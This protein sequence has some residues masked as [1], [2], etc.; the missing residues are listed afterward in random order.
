MIVPF[1]PPTIADVARRA[2]VSAA[3]V[4]YVLSGRQDQR[5]SAETRERIAQAVTEL[6]Y[7]QNQIA[8]QLR[9]R[10]TK[11]I[12]VLLPQIGIPFADNIAQDVEAAVRQRGYTSVVVVGRSYDMCRQLVLDV[13]AGLADGIVAEVEQFSAHQIS[14]LFEPVARAQ[15]AAL[16]LHPTMEP[17]T[18]STVRQARLPAFKAMLERLHESGRRSFA[19]IRHGQSDDAHRSETLQSFLS[20]KGLAAAPVVTGAETRD[21]AVDAAL[22][23]LTREQRPD[24]LLVQSDFSAVAI[25]QALHRRGIRVPEDV[26]IAGSGNA[27][28]GRHCFPQLTT[29]GPRRPSLATAVDHLLDEI[30]GKTDGRAQTFEIPWSVIA[31]ESA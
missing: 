19:Y 5:I 26:A 8:R 14:E 18:F 6:G 21:S 20:S 13:E 17:D 15:K 31:R 1:R 23:L 28:E 7:V 24:A 16:L 11:R 22:I 2:N 30:E 25:I 3:T 9:L 27:E 29:I 4:S 10:R 12:C